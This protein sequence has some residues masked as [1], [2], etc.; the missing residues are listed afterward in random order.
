MTSNNKAL[1][2][3]RVLIIEDDY[4]QATDEA[5]TIELA[6]GTVAASTAD[7]DDACVLITAGNIDFALVDINL[8]YGPAF[9]TARTLRDQGIPFIFI[10]G[11]DAATVPDEFQDVVLVQKP[12]NRSKLM[13]ALALIT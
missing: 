1:D 4:Y 9:Q 13:S 2:G 5:M 10:T 11:Y 3:K 12:I 7:A 6:G 8:G